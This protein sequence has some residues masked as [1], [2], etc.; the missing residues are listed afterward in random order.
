MK[1]LILIFSL[2]LF[3][4][5]AHHQSEARNSEHICMC[6]RNLDPVCGTDGETYSN[7][8]TLRCEADTVRGRSV[9]LRIAHYGDCN[10]NFI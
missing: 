9:G 8:C 10:E 6:P 3:T 4:I 7:P 2:V 1:S 5:L